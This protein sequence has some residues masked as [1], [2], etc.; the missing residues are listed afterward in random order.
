MV[1]GENE[2]SHD[3][4]VTVK[5]NDITTRLSDGVEDTGWVNTRDTSTA[6]IL[7]WLLEHCVTSATDIVICNIQP[8]PSRMGKGPA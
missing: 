2:I 3:R 7:E 4:Q 5:M 1:R 8:P 6:V